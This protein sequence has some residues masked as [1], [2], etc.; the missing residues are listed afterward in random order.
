[1]CGNGE[2]SDRT[3]A[4]RNLANR[5]RPLKSPWARRIFPPGPSAFG[6]LALAAGARATTLA[7]GLPAVV[8]TA[9]AAARSH[10]LAGLAQCHCTQNYSERENRKDTLHLNLL[11][12]LKTAVH[13]LRWRAKSTPQRHRLLVRREIPKFEEP[14]RG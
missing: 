6:L 10:Q 13:K 5:S 8:A 9:R 14:A 12:T 7:A 3:G 4:D 1:M 11:L 2:S